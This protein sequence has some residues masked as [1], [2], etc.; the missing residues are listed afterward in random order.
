[1]NEKGDVYRQLQ[2]HMD[3]MPIPFPATESGVEL[4]IL[5]HFFSPEE[6]E[7]A[8]ALNI[9]L[10]SAEKIHKRLAGSGLNIEELEKTLDKLAGRGS[11]LRE[12]KTTKT[13]IVKQY[14]K[15]PLL[16]GIFEYQVNRLKKDFVEDFQQ[17]MD[18]SF[19]S[20]LASQKTDQIRSV[21]INT[22]IVMEKIV[23]SY[24]DIK[25]YVR[26]TEGPYGVMN[27][28]CRQAKD[29]AGES[30]SRDDIMETC[31]SIGEMAKAVIVAGVGRSVSQDE[32]ILLLNRAEKEGFVLNPENS[33]NPRF[34]CCCCGECCV[35]LKNAKKL[36]KPVEF[37]SGNYFAVV[38]T[39]KCVGCK[40]CERRCQ[41]DAIV[42]NGKKASIDL[43]RCIGCGLCATTCN[44]EAIALHAKA[45]PTV[46]AKNTQ[47]M[48]QKILMER[49]GMW[50]G[51]KVAGKLMLGKKV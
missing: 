32:F 20:E 41:M 22:Q 5:K 1:M 30:C 17:Y 50:R 19:R 2:Q 49:Y 4:K 27:C 23:G 37:I 35:I 24:D 14:S 7:V 47:A 31:L 36:P 13:G 51:M 16:F 44:T 40:T 28:V 11:I 42:V 45:K 38:D 15:M 48:Y 46:P 43:D 8:L 6:A 12:V 26:G 34:I 33:Q 9:V 10:E 21:P 18:E 25:Q 39:E 3:K 29:A